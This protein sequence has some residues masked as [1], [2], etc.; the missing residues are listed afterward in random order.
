[1]KFRWLK[2]CTVNSSATSELAICIYKASINVDNWGM[3]RGE[4]LHESCQEITWDTI[5]I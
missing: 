1:M 3:N 5:K 2:G 4:I